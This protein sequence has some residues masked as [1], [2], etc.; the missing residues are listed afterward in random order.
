MARPT[1]FTD[2]FTALMKRYGFER[3]EITDQNRAR[4]VHWRNLPGDRHVIIE[5]SDYHKNTLPDFRQR[6]AIITV[7]AG[8]DLMANREHQET[9]YIAEDLSIFLEEFFGAICETHES[10]DYRSDNNTEYSFI[11]EMTE[12][13]PFV[14]WGILLSS[15]HKGTARYPNLDWIA[16][17]IEFFTGPDWERVHQNFSAHLCGNLCTRFVQERGNFLLQDDYLGG[18][19]LRSIFTRVQLNGYP[20]HLY[21]H[22]RMNAMADYLRDHAE[23][24]LPIPDLKTRDHAT[25]DRSRYQFLHDC[26]RGR[27]IIPEYWPAPWFDQYV[28]YAGGIRY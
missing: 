13:Y 22:Y 28:G 23:I 12:K 1:R 10:H 25:K 21:E 6:H 14:E 27:G 20:D 3:I 8:P 15:T 5:P 9:A 18:P 19:A 26:S 7:Y 11:K 2:V 17:L 4:W 24:V 16:G